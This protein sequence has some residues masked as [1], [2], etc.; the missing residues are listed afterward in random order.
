MGRLLIGLLVLSLMVNFA[1]G[2]FAQDIA[3]K[4]SKTAKENQSGNGSSISVDKELLEN[5]DLLLNLDLI[6]NLPVI[7]DLES[8]DLSDE[9]L[10]EF[11][12]ELNKESGGE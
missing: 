12:N 10:D 5:L 9:E 1:G 6:E 11:F 7:A 2:S 8:L 3:A 4:E